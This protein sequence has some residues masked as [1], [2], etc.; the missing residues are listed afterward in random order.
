[1]SYLLMRGTVI[2]T[3]DNPATVDRK[4]GEKRDAYRQVQLMVCEP[5]RDGQ[6]R[7]DVKTLS[8]DATA[9]FDALKGS[10]AL[11]EVG[12]YVRNGSLAFYA[13]KGSLPIA[14]TAASGASG[15]TAAA[16]GAGGR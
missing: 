11:V 1:M 12:A 16:G 8:V 4:T 7:F 2:N 13:K 15:A 5:L 6:S 3:I 10:E 14:A 9:P